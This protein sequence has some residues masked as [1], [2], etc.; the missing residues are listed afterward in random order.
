M[1]NYSL[2]FLHVLHFYVFASLLLKDFRKPHTA[3]GTTLDRQSI[4]TWDTQAECD[5][6][7]QLLQSGKAKQC[8]YKGDACLVWVLPIVSSISDAYGLSSS[9]LPASSMQFSLS[10]LC[11]FPPPNASAHTAA[12]IDYPNMTQAANI[13]MSIS[14]QQ[15]RILPGGW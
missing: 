9:F 11:T 1:W 5:S 8:L 2:L 14:G 3:H 7:T 6:G 4:V 12:V 13:L 10:S 15:P